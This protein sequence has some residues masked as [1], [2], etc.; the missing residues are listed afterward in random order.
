MKYFRKEQLLDEVRKFVKKEGSQA[1]AAFQ[2]GVCA[3]VLGRVLTGERGVPD[4]M[5]KGLGL[6]TIYVKKEDL[7][8][9]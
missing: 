8:K 2:L 6:E 5:I 3:T 9:T 4:S 1:G 7:E